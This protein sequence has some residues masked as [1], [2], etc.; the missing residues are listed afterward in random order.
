MSVYMTLGRASVNAGLRR[1]N[2]SMSEDNV[3]ILGPS[4]VR[5][6]PV[7]NSQGLSA[8][9]YQSAIVEG[10][11]CHA[12]RRAVA[13]LALRLGLEVWTYDHHFDVMSV[14]VWR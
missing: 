13:T 7:H 3:L 10:P 5:G 12:V 8:R 1:V 11:A 4:P 14:A 2:S 6:L 9:R